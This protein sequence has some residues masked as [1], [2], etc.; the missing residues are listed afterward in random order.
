MMAYLDA[1]CVIYLVEQNPVWG[2]LANDREPT[3]IRFS[4]PGNRRGS[5]RGALPDAPPPPSARGTGQAELLGSETAVGREGL[6]A[7]PGDLVPILAQEDDHRDAVATVD[8]KRIAD[9]GPCVAVE[10]P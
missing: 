6:L 2:P 9:V 4:G 10:E 1:N 7:E 5:P 8:R 3:P